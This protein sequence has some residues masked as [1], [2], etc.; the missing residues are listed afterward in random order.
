MGRMIENAASR[1]ALGVA[2]MRAAHQLL[3]GEPRLFPDPIALPLLGP[4]AAERIR[5]S[6]D[7]H[8]TPFWRGMRSHVCLRSRFAE[9][10]LAEAQGTNWYVLVGAGYDTFAFRQPDWA[11]RVRIVE[12]DHPATQAAKQEM[13]RVAGIE[14]PENLTFVA[15]DFTCETLLDM[16]DPLQIAPDDSVYF[17]WLGVT[18]Y[19]EPA[20]VDATLAAMAATA[21]NVRICLSFKQ[22]TNESISQDVR[23]AEAVASIGEPFLSLFTP[24]EMAD[25]LAAHGFRAQE[26]LTADIARSRYFTPPRRG[27]PAP[28]HT[29][30]VWASK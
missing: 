11:R 5:D 27:I 9:D 2:Y 24:E 17:S 19:L 10:K 6:L 12:V 14:T 15:A 8:Q 23:F 30:I 7:R 18:M 13:L 4:D 29:T 22:P 25:K 1:T 20:A 16:L 26:F 28:H 3:D 21:R